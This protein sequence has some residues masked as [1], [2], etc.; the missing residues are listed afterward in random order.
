MLFF[1]QDRLTKSLTSLQWTSS[2]YLY[3][4][5][6]LPFKLDFVADGYIDR[7]KTCVLT[8]RHPAF[9][10]EFPLIVLQTAWGALWRWVAKTCDREVTVEIEF[11]VTANRCAVVFSNLVSN[12]FLFCFRR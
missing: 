1:R 5:S 4:Q 3:F 9:S 10:S 12:H 11:T 6:I 8:C 7:L 2:C